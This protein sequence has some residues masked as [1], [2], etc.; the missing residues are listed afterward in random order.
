MMAHIMSTQLTP[1]AKTIDR[2]YARAP[3]TTAT[4]NVTVSAVPVSHR[5][6][7]ALCRG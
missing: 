4:A 3:D 1:N 5:I 2:P 6:H 7:A